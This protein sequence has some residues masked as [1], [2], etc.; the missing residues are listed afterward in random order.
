MSTVYEDYGTQKARD[1]ARQHK[2]QY[3]QLVRVVCSPNPKTITMIYAKGTQLLGRCDDGYF[4][5][6]G[7]MGSGTSNFWA[8]LNENGFRISYDNLIEIG[9]PETIMPE[10][11]QLSQQHI[12]RLEERNQR[13]EEEKQRQG[14]REKQQMTEE[15]QRQKEE[16]KRQQAQKVE[17][18]RRS[19]VQATRK[20]SAQCVMCGQ[21]LGVFLKLLGKD[22]HGKC[23]TFSE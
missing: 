19:R 14:E 13:W 10:T 2:S 7:Y 8:F 22:R 20:S 16:A 6:F 21:K 4:M 18:E 3:G 23:T 17:D 1:I 11:T 5:Q 9:T 15:K 12:K